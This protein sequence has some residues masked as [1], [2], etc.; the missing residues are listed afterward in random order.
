MDKILHHLGALRY[1]NSWDFGDLR[2]CKISSINSITSGRLPWEVEIS[3]EINP[4]IGSAMAE[5]H[6]LYSV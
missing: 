1:C 3:T 5:V 4:S 2:W 6:M